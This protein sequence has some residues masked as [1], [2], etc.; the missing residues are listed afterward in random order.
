LVDKQDEIDK[1]LTPSLRRHIFR[2]DVP[3]SDAA[4]TVTPPAA[5]DGYAPAMM[6]PEMQRKLF[7]LW[8]FPRPSGPCFGAGVEDVKRRNTTGDPLDTT[9]SRNKKKSTKDLHQAYTA[10][11]L[12][13]MSVFRATQMV[14]QSAPG[15]CAR[16][17]YVAG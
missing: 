1:R 12:S 15:L 16:G 9:T 8:N 10:V 5:F 3:V 14:G 17:R 13:A 11:F 6:H 2:P 4:K 7:S